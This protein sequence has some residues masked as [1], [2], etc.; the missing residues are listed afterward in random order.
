MRSTLD[1]LLH[2][3]DPSQTY[4]LAREV[5]IA[6]LYRV[7]AQITYKT[8]SVVQY[9]PV[10]SYTLQIHPMHVDLCTQKRQV[11][12]LAW[13]IPVTVLPWRQLYVYPLP[14]ELQVSSLWLPRSALPPL[15]RYAFPWKGSRWSSISKSRQARSWWA[16]TCWSYACAQEQEPIEI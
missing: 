5:R 1:P 13:M 6:C 8:D 14:C 11:Q 4:C 15:P 16:K 9:K 10:I 7:H 12:Y 2:I 3:A